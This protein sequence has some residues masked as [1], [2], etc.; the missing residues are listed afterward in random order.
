MHFNVYIN[1][2]YWQGKILLQLNLFLYT[3]ITNNNNHFPFVKAN[4]QCSFSLK[5]FVWTKSRFTLKY[6]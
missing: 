6:I 2:F 3:K 5:K 4:S 1:H